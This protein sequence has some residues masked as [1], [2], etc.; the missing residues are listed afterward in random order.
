MPPP[1]DPTFFEANTRRRHPT[2]HAP[3]IR[4][5]FFSR[6]RRPA[7]QPTHLA[8]LSENMRPRHLIQ[9]F[10]GEICCPSVR[11]I[12]NCKIR[13]PANRPDLFLEKHAPSLSDPAS[14]RRIC[15][16]RASFYAPETIQPN[17]FLETS[18]PRHPTWHRAGLA[19]I[20]ICINPDL[21]RPKFAST[22]TCV[23]PNLL[24]P[25]RPG[26]DLGNPL[27]RGYPIPSWMLGQAGARCWASRLS[28]T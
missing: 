17:F 8:F 20:P 11:P 3:A 9:L 4:P 23:N 10:S 25:Q 24:G 2:Q 1:S 15:A 27:L 26:Y 14:S 22:Q 16:I 28:K 21:R 18:G 19:S 7:I 6:N 5:F 13:I 12:F